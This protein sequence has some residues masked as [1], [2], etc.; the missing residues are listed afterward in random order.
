MTPRFILRKGK[1]FG[2]RLFPC[3]DDGR[4]LC[5]MAGRS[6]LTA[7]E[8]KALM[9]MGIQITC[10]D[11]FDAWEFPEACC[12]C[13]RYDNENANEP[14]AVLDANT[15]LCEFCFEEEGNGVLS[16]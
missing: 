3:N 16:I 9:N 6:H 12:Q 8:I 5:D 4:K 10:Y 14:V 13:G 7:E 15:K 1:P 2:M 11:Q